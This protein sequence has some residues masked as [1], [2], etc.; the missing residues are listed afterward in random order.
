MPHS[1][2]PASSRASL[3][4]TAARGAA[5]PGEARRAGR[6]SERAPSDRSGSDERAVS[7][8]PPAR[9][10]GAESARTGP[11]AARTAAG[12]RPACRP[13]SIAG[14][15]RRAPAGHGQTALQSLHRTLDTRRKACSAPG[16]PGPTARASV[17][18][19]ARPRCSC[20]I[21]G[22]SAASMGRRSTTRSNCSGRYIRLRPPR[23]E[24]AL[25]LARG[26]V[27]ALPEIDCADRATHRQLAV[28]ASGRGRPA[29][30][31]P[32]PCTSCC[33]RRTP[34][35]SSS[36]KRWSWPRPSAASAR[37]PSSTA[38]STPCGARSSEERDRSSAP[39]T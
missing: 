12:G 6:A 20:C 36:T 31:A 24:L 23:R 9:K 7:R 2:R 26:A 29:H 3:P 8:R 10:A 22:T 33:S 5:P 15:P 18:G 27:G 25:G 16:R 17:I 21:S 34:R 14:A 11:S 35:R 19:P 28:G 4:P 30:H 32:W 38:C 39:G 37:S 13:E 1:R